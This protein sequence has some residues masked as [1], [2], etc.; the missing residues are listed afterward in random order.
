MAARSSSEGARPLRQQLIFP[1]R[2]LL[3]PPPVGLMNRRQPP[4]PATQQACKI[5]ELSMSALAACADGPSPVQIPSLPRNTPWMARSCSRVRLTLC[6]DK[7]PA[8]CC[9]QRF[10]VWARLKTSSASDSTTS[11]NNIK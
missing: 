10:S 3:S 2:L 1:R 7:A 11:Y 5:A 4:A 8:L 9:T 6:R